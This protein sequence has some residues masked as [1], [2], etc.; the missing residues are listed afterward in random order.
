[1]TKAIYFDMDGTLANLYAVEGW[2]NMLREHDPKP[3]V[4]AEPLIRL[5]ALARLLNRLQK[6]GYIIGIVSW[7]S[8]DP[9]PSYNKAVTEAKLKWLANHLPSVIW[10]E[11]YIVP[12]GMP[13][14]KVVNNPFG[15]LFDDEEQ[16][17]TNW[18]GTAYDVDNII[19]ILKSL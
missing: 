19:E 8:K 15:I 14:Q 13:K 17:R 9:T 4:I 1:M 16:N 3:Y 11:I 18:N 5:S 2:L 12:Y 10:D 6:E 7:L